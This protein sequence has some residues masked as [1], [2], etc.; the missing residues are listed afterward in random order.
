MSILDTLDDFKNH[1][2]NAAV[3]RR[4]RARAKESR[5]KTQEIKMKRHLYYVNVEKP[6]K[7][8]KKSSATVSVVPPDLLA[9]FPTD[10]RPETEAD[11][12]PVSAKFSAIH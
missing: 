6:R 12:T 1:S 8:A 2:C 3:K 10:T 7:Q 9:D 4:Q 5:E 11:V